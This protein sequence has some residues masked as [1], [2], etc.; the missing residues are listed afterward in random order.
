[1][2]IIFQRK[3][4]LN[5]NNHNPENLFEYAASS[6]LKHIEINLSSEKFGLKTFTKDKISKLKNLSD[7]H[8]IQLSF[9]IPY[10]TNISDILIHLR[11]S[12]IKYLSKSIQLASEL[13]STHVTLHLGNFYW[14]PVEKWERRKALLRFIKSLVKILKLCEEKGVVIALENVVP[15]PSGSEYYLLGDNIDDFEYIFSNVESEYLK[16]CLDTGHANMAEGVIE[17]INNFHEKLSCIHYHDNNGFNDEHLAIGEGKVPW[18]EL[19]S[20]LEDINFTG[21]IISEC[22]GIKA[23]ESALLFENY[24]TNN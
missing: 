7:E 2:S 6:G 15:I 10:Y 1:M 12:S 5:V 23:H 21:P 24:F 18:Q 4:G 19:A 9:H 8:N 17:Y 13:K 3:Y 22:R 11:R 16:F 14:F 20:K